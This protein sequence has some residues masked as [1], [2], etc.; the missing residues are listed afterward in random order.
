MNSGY[1]YLAQERHD[2]NRVLKRVGKPPCLVSHFD[3]SRLFGG[4]GESTPNPP[5]SEE[6]SFLSFSSMITDRRFHT[7]EG[8]GWRM[9]A[10]PLTCQTSPDNNVLTRGQVPSSPIGYLA[11]DRGR[12]INK[13]LMCM[14]QSE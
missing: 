6:R 8:Y 14:L 13:P 10:K 2:Q 3:L 4:P 9:P 1:S 11:L 5:P 12:N 7:C